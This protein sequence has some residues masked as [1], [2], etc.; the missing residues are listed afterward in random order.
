MRC[1]I[2]R[3]KEMRYYH[4]MLVS[5]FFIILLLVGCC[6]FYLYSWQ[7]KEEGRV[8]RVEIN[9]IV[10]EIRKEGF[11]RLDL[12]KYHTITA[13]YPWKEEATLETESEYVLREVSGMWYQIE[14]TRQTIAIDSELVIF[15][16]GLLLF[17][18]G[19]LMGG[20]LFI[21]QKI[22][23][24]FKE[25]E[26]VAYELSKGNLTIPVQENRYRFFGKFVWG[27]NLLREHM[28]QQKEHELALQ[29]EKK[30]LLLSLS[31]DIK[32]PLLAIKLYAKALSKGLYEEKE[33]QGQIAENINRK[34]DEIESFVS[35]IIKAAKEDF[36]NLEVI[37][38]EFYLS[39]I[40]EKL[41]E[42]YVDKLAF[43]K[44]RFTI[45]DYSDCLLKG[46]ANRLV[47]VLQNVIENAVKYGDG[48]SIAISILKEEDC[49]LIRVTNSGCT[50]PVA[51]LPHIFESFWRGS[52]AG[53]SSGSGLGL[54]ICRKL[55]RAMDGE[56]FA[57]IKEGKM[58]VTVV[59]REV[60]YQDKAYFTDC[61][62]M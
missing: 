2:M 35:E 36:L 18:A 53:D 62:I 50:L 15:I 28:E 10:Q 11:L 24:P 47:E 22:L 6:N 12:S 48:G 52:N 1:R 40:I 37:Q 33:K 7:Q 54:Y 3:V 32:T 30:T 49:R 27:I 16:N 55:V 59:A 9:R 17:M 45:G 20:M 51:E 8:H 23:K 34:A 46:D 44:T 14:Y 21:R 56:I 61:D 38:G 19:L 4:K 42:Y 25:L 43:I 13:V 31:H 60:S 58:C 5:V 41:E 57:E 39:A 26:S 29:R